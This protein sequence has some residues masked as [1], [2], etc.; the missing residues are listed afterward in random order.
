V[1]L[2]RAGEEKEG[3]TSGKGEGGRWK[4]KGEKRDGPER[5]DN[6]DGRT[7]AEDGEPFLLM[8]QFNNGSEKSDEH[9]KP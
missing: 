6:K 7:I 9:N 2:R 1:G 5:N 4:G 3:R 8:P